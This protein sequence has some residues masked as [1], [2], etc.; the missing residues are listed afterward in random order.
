M[1]WKPF[2]EEIAGLRRAPSSPLVSRA[3]RMA[4]PTAEPGPMD[5]PYRPA[6]PPRE[7]LR[8][9][10]PFPA[11]PRSPKWAR[12]DSRAGGDRRVSRVGRCCSRGKPRS[13]RPVWNAGDAA[14]PAS[15]RGL[16]STSDPSHR[17]GYAR[18]NGGSSSTRTTGSP[19][20]AQTPAFPWRIPRGGSWGIEHPLL[21]VGNL[22]ARPK[23]APELIPPPIPYD[24]S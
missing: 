17:M 15:I 3:F 7:G 22:L 4:S 23:A 18:R 8:A 19:R 12:P 14:G 24:P 1:G 16:P 10:L 2:G 9:L 21:L 11:L 5:G 6:P 13:K 20:S